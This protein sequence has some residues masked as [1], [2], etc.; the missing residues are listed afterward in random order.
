MSLPKWTLSEMKEIIMAFLALSWGVLFLFPEDTL[1]QA[2]RIDLLSIYAGDTT[3]G[4]FLVIAALFL[5]F[6]PRNRYFKLRRRIH[7]G[8]W[9]FWLGI[10]ILVAIAG[11]RNGLSVTD[12]LFVTTFLTFAFLHAAFYSRLAVN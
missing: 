11:T 5:L 7:L 2:S 3:W 6:I 4:L 12:G 10:T 8:L 1:G 9:W